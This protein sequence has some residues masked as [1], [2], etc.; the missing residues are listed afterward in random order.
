M[1]ADG[2]TLKD[3]VSGIPIAMVTTTT[4]GLLRGRPLAVQRV[5]LD[6]TVW[7]LVDRHADWVTTD[8]GVVNIAFVDT[9]TWVSATGS[10]TTTDDQRILDD[11]GDPVTDTW[12]EDGAEPVALR[13][14]VDHADWWD[15]PGRLRQAVELIAAKVGDRQPD[16]GSRGVSEP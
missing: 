4:R 11:L 2:Q 16:M 9:T 14:V 7:F 5:D 10:A 15:A 12:F 8:L 13:V 3:L 1:S 6:G